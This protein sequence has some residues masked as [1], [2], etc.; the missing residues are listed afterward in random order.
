MPNSIKLSCMKLIVILL[1]VTIMAFGGN[2]PYIP[3]ESPM[4]KQSSQEVPLEEI[5][6]E[7]FKG[8][9]MR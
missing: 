7:K 6:S 2:T 8:L 1:G 3:P 9:S 4:L 5:T